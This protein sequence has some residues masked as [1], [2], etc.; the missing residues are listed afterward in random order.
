MRG[1]NLALFGLVVALSLSLDLWTK[2]LAR[3]ALM[4]RG[5]LRPLVVVPGYFHLRYGENPEGAFNLLQDLPGGRWVFAV[6]IMGALVFCVVYQ[7]LNPAAS[8][9]LGVALG[10]VAA[11]AIGNLLDRMHYGRVTDFIVW[12]IGRYEWPAFNLADVAL[13]VGACL[14]VLHVI[15]SRVAERRRG[16]HPASPAR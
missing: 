5:P 9:L 16:D 15:V 4:P 14:V 2:A 7:R 6:L 11:G 10:L 8:A 12:K 13:C 1:R 3:E